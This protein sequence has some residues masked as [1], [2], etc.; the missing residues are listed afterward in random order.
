MHHSQA[1]L[2]YSPA[3]SSYLLPRRTPAAG[4]TRNNN[5]ET[6][7]QNVCSPDKKRNLDP[8]KNVLLRLYPLYSRAHS[9]LVAPFYLS[10]LICLQ[11]HVCPCP[12]CV[13]KI[14]RFYSQDRLFPAGPM[15]QGHRVL[16]LTVHAFLFGV[17][18]LFY[19]THINCIVWKPVCYVPK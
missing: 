11:E 4:N 14:I 2:R 13:H 18:D 6:T 9:A 1:R 3:S 19:L 7:W 16:Y 17:L 12:P 5:K 10:K 15:F 8:C